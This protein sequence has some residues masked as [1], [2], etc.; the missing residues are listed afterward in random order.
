MYPQL[1]IFNSVFLNGARESK[2][3]HR[4]VPELHLIGICTPYL[5]AGF[6]IVSN[7]F[8]HTKLLFESYWYK[9]MP[10]PPRG[11][12]RRRVNVTKLNVLFAYRKETV[13]HR[14]AVEEFC[15]QQLLPN[16]SVLMHSRTYD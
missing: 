3:A 4:R 8:N 12:I 13:S 15:S 2:A 5:P 16:E 10:T 6:R 11:K 14:Y 7:D 9:I 1:P